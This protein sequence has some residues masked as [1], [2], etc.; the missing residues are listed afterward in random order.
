[1]NENCAR[2][3]TAC[4]SIKRRREGAYTT[5]VT[6]GEK[7]INSAASASALLEET[8]AFGEKQIADGGE[9]RE[10]LARVKEILDY[11]N[12]E[13]VASLSPAVR[14]NCRNRHELCA[15]WALL[16]KSHMTECIRTQIGSSQI[17]PT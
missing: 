9:R 1:M 2:S 4:D 10:T 5:T 14:E 7:K 15:F 3:C 8:A 12:S 13:K 6:T 11:M 17:I 16:G